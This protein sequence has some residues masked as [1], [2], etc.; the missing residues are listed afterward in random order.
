MTT[1]VLTVRVTSDSAAVGMNTLYG[2][3]IAGGTS[4]NEI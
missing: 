3:G 4:D 1:W 2:N